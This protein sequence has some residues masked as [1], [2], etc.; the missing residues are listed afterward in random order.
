[1]K[2]KMSV[3][4]F[5]PHILYFFGTTLSLRKQALARS[6][7]SLTALGMEVYLVKI[8]LPEI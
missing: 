2:A 1:M 6:R 3:K 7:I 4:G 5:V 8:G